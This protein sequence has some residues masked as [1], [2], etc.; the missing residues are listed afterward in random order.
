MSISFLL[1]KLQTIACLIRRS[2]SARGSPLVLYEGGRRLLCATLWLILDEDE[3]RLIDE[4]PFPGDL[5]LG[6]PDQSEDRPAK[7]E[8][9]FDADTFFNKMNCNACCQT[10]GNR[11][12]GMKMNGHDELHYGCPYPS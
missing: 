6:D 8:K 10:T 1:N 5:E 7:Q 3:M 2:I 9:E 11:A 4:L 12:T